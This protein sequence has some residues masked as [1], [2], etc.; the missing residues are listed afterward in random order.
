[1]DVSFTL[2]GIFCN[3]KGIG[4]VN[5]LCAWENLKIYYLKNLNFC[6]RP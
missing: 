5:F 3:E 4:N 2:F 1:M 6:M